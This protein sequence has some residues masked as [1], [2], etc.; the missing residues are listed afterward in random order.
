MRKS[1]IVILVLLLVAG[2]GSL[3][4]ADLALSPFKEELDV[5]SRLTRQ[6][7]ERGDLVADSTVKLRRITQHEGREGQGLNLE[8]WPSVAVQTRSGGMR[9][10]AR[11]LAREAIEAYGVTGSGIRWFRIR[12]F[13]PGDESRDVLLW[14]DTDNQVGDPQPS[15]PSTWPPAG[16][17]PRDPP[18]P[19]SAPA[20]APAK[21]GG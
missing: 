19:A 2:A 12:V 7:G 9:A 6:F 17:A 5:A 14:R 4:V 13:L 3:L 15:L 1:T 10:L 21:P 16:S 20:S 18:G 8:V 11:N